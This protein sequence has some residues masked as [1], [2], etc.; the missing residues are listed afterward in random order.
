MDYLVA[1]F[2]ENRTLLFITKSNSHLFI[3]DVDVK[4]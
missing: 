4:L 3:F 1:I 2:H